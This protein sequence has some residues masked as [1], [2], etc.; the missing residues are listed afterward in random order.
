M[1]PVIGI[2]QCLD[3][4]GRWRAGRSYAYVDLAY[5]SAVETAGGLA[6]HL[7]LQDDSDALA[8]RIDGLLIPGGDDFAPP[9][10]ESYPADAG[11]DPAPAAQIAFYRRMLE[12][13][14][15]SGLPVLGICY[16]MQL[17][18][19]A[20]G[21]ALHYHLPSDQPDAQPHQ[22]PEG[23]G[24]HALQVERGSRLA[25][26]LGDPAEPVN[27]LHHQAVS[28]PGRGAR[29]CAR[30]PDG[31]I[32]AIEANDGHFELGVQWHPEKLSGDARV[33]LFEALVEA[34]R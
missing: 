14:R 6:L 19:L 18:A 25:A 34:C 32:E 24:R 2:T 17:L 33:R 11:F 23:D 30:A 31:V 22:L 27:S 7:P 29:V 13:A 10:P 3:D 5:A 4:R 16:G 21:G 12:S 15:R 8:A 26:I 1:R 20:R 9:Q 28:D